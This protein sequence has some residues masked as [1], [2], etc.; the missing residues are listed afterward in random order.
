MAE[1]FVEMERRRMEERILQQQEE[2][3]M[4]RKRLQEIE[5]ELRSSRDG[6]EENESSNELDGRS[7]AKRLVGIYGDEIPGMV[8]PMELD[9]N[10]PEPFI[11]D[12]KHTDKAANQS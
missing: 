3:E 7:F 10:D 12:V 2:V 1:E 5:F 4:V 9:M 8:M 11:H 6:K